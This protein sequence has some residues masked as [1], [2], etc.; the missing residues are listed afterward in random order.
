MNRFE[1]FPSSPKELALPIT[2]HSLYIFLDGPGIDYYCEL[3]QLVR[4][5]IL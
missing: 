4:A 1:L 2:L 5:S 3:A